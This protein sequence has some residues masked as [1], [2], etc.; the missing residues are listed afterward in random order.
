MSGRP[1][2][3]GAGPLAGRVGRLSRSPPIGLGE[4]AHEKEIRQRKSVCVLRER[5][6]VVDDDTLPERPAGGNKPGVML[7]LGLVELV[8]FQ[9]FEVK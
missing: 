1:R 2:L 3:A 4:E 9:R 6:D 5:S 7:A 8:V